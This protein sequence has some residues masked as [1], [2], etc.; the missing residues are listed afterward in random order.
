[1]PGNKELA[2]LIK[3][4]QPKVGIN[5]LVV[6]DNAVVS[7]LMR[8]ILETAGY[9]VL[10]VD[11]GDKALAA[12]TDWFPD[13]IL[14]DLIL[15]TMNGFE[16]MRL[17][18]RSQR[19]AHIP[20]II[21]STESDR[22]REGMNLGVDDYLPKPFAPDDLLQA[23]STRLRRNQVSHG[24]LVEE[25]ILDAEMRRD[26]EAGKLK[27]YYQKIVTACGGET[28]AVEALLRWPQAD[29][30]FRPPADWIPLAERT[31]F[32]IALGAWVLERACN[33]VQEVRVKTGKA[34]RLSVNVSARQLS[35]PG[36][37]VSVSEILKRS[38]L[39]ADGLQIEVTETSAMQDPPLAMRMLREIADLGVK[40]A[41]DD[42]G[43]GYSSLIYL[44]ELPINS[45]KID[46][47]FIRDLPHDPAAVAIV[48]NILDLASK[49]NLEVV[50][51]GIELADQLHFLTEN[52]CPF[53]QGFLLGRPEP[54]SHLIG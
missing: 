32:I 37:A 16:V 35:E 9:V 30:T 39:P 44:K 33:E 2:P 8:M 48:R 50:A 13:L 38:G 4:S 45:L 29:G 42:F 11:D 53:A 26:L 27:I 1:M 41:I 31:G 36:F 22:I 52:G 51:E 12:V 21:V 49:L 7:Q 28:V 17:M 47:A 3:P 46:R 23:V 25:V 40:I 5:I 10:V 6:E 19:L 24:R 18:Q 54:A 14:C 15:P 34:I 20:F 43:T